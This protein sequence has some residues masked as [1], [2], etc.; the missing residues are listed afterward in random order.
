MVILRDKIKDRYSED[1][2]K[3][4]YKKKLNLGDTR[5]WFRERRRM[6]VRVKAKRSSA[7]RD[8]MTCIHCESDDIESLEHMEK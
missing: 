4:D 8:D 5:N 3:G 1:K 2:K 6:T 7:F